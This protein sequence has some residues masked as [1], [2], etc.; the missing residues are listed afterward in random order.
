MGRCPGGYLHAMSTASPERT[1]VAEMQP[2][3]TVN[4]VA[5]HDDAD[6]ARETLESLERAGLDGLCTSFVSGSPA[7]TDA[8]ARFARL[9]AR[10][11]G[12][13][14]L[15]GIAVGLVIGVVAAAV[16]AGVTDGSASAVW[17]GSLIGF[18]AFGAAAGAFYT[19]FTHTAASAAWRES[20]AADPDA[21]AR[22][23]VHLDDPGELS[24]IR[25][26]LDE[27]PTVSVRVLDRRGRPRAPDTTG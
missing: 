10:R 26:L 13:G 17:A 18:A 3:R 4:V 12:S 27:S 25:A 7:P 19:L 5:V 22:V 21:S 23:V 15:T 2:F 14:A 11:L 20:F 6:D 9:T 1:T 24:E 8:D 16:L